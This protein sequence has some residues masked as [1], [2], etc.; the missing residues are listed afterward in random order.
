CPKG[1]RCCECVCCLPKET[2]WDYSN[3]SLWILFSVFLAM[4]PLLFICGLMKRFCCQSRVVMKPVEP[5][6]PYSLRPEDPVGPMRYT[7]NTAF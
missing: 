6:P 1:F 3:E 5:P 4:I 2:I 7:D